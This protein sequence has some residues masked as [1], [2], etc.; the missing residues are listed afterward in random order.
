MGRGAYHVFQAE[1]GAARARGDTTGAIALS[2]KA[3]AAL[4]VNPGPGRT[5]PA[6]PAGGAVRM[7]AAAG[8]GSPDA[9]SLVRGIEA[10]MAAAR[11]ALPR[12]G[13]LAGMDAGL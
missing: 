13:T 4:V 2:A 11:D 3:G 7:A 6:A 9:A 10:N 8:T 5:A 1:A 12:A